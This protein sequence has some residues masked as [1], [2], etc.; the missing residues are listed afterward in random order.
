[1]TLLEKC[2][3]SIYFSFYVLVGG[4]LVQYHVQDTYIFSLTD[5]ADSALT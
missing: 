5:F 3:E 2:P 1:M 4:D